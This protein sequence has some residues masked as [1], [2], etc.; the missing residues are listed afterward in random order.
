MF[1]E[2]YQHPR[3]GEVYNLGGG[4][5]SSLSILETIDMLRAMGFTLKY[6]VTDQTRTGD[7]ICYISDL[8]KVRSHFPGWR[9]KHRIEDIVGELVECYSAAERLPVW[10]SPQVAPAK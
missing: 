9:Q 1:L 4:R 10:L 8:S 6:E 7:H 2:F 5:S 3:S